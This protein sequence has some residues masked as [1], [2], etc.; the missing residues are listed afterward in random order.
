MDAFYLQ[1]MSKVLDTWTAN[2]LLQKY[3]G[4]KATSDILNAVGSY[5]K[6]LEQATP[7]EKNDQPD[8]IKIGDNERESDNDNIAGDM[9][10][11]D[12]AE[13]RNVEQHETTDTLG[14]QE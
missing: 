3:G 11:K 14:N 1:E 10:T 12:T 8:S 6:Q 4:Q 9:Y 5:G 2:V 13:Q 7:L